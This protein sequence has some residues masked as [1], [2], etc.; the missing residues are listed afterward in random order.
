MHGLQQTWAETIRSVRRRGIH[1]EALISNACY[2]VFLDV[3]AHFDSFT[4]EKIAASV[5]HDWH[6]LKYLARNPVGIAKRGARLVPDLLLSPDLDLLTESAPT[7][8]EEKAALL[9]KTVR[10]IPTFMEEQRAARASEMRLAIAQLRAAGLSYGQICRL[11]DMAASALGIT[12]EDG[13][14]LEYD[15]HTIRRV[16]ARR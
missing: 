1:I 8:P 15:P 5:G 16:N 10:R 11:L 2:Y 13:K 14:P 6:S 3:S 12:S 4:A 9:S 7:T